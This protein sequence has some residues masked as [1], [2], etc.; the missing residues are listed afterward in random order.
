M[1]GEYESRY[2]RVNEADLRLWGF[3][4]MVGAAEPFG[5]ERFGQPSSRSTSA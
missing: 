1:F 2:A 5:N 3:G 4:R